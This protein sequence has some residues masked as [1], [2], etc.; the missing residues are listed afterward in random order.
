[1][2]TKRRLFPEQPKTTRTGP[3]RCDYH[4]HGIGC[5]S[6]G[7]L[8]PGTLGQGPWYC[9]NH[10]WVFLHDG[11]KSERASDSWNQSKAL[12][13]QRVLTGAKREPGED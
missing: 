12:M 10:A 6:I 2:V 8:S 7:T 5:N 1:M 9:R 11:H 4:D 3:A 13:P